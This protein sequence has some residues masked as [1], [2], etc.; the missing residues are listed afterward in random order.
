VSARLDAWASW[1]GWTERSPHF[2]ASMAPVALG[3][4]SV[5]ATAAAHDLVLLTGD[6]ES[7]ELS[8]RPCQVEGL[9]SL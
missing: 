3:D 6:P 4:C 9:R 5:M 8:D 7:V 2:L 1:P